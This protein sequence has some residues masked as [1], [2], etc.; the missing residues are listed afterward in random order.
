[1]EASVVSN[2]SAALAAGIV[3]KVQEYEVEGEVR[4]FSPGRFYGLVIPDSSDGEYGILLHASVLHKFECRTVMGGTRIRAFATGSGKAARI[5]RVISID[6]SHAQPVE[7][8]L[9]DVPN[10]HVVASSELKRAEVKWFS[11]RKGFGFLVDEDGTDLFVHIETLRRYGIIGLRSGQNMLVRYGAG[12]KG[13]V[14]TEIYEDK[15][16]PSF[17]M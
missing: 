14:A 11:T 8:Y 1:M 3:P 10:A 2:Q 16:R 6:N 13:F 15:N 17:L 7:R 9:S 12:K 5:T 4:W